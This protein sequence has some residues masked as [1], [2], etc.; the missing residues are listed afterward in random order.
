M[1]LKKSPLAPGAFPDLPEISGVRFASGNSGMRYK[2]R[3]DVMLAEFDPETTV[4]G[5]F[6]KNAMPGAPVDWG[7]KILPAGQARGLVVNAGI[8]NVFTGAAGK[9]TVEDTAATAAQLLNASPEHI[10]VASTGVIGDLVP[11]EKIT[12][13]LPRLAEDL[14]ADAGEAAANCILTTD[15]FAKGA[16]ATAKIGDRLVTISGFAKGSGMI[17]PDMATMLAF[18][19]TDAAV[20]APIL[21]QLLSEANEKSFNCVTVDS[22]TSTSDTVLVFATGRA[23]NEIPA[24]AMDGSL[25]D[26]KRALLDVMAN[27]AQQ[28]ARDGEGASKFITVK[29]TG[30]ESD[31][32][33]KTIALAIAN[34]PLVKTAIAGEDANWGRIIMAV[35][36]SGEKANR[37]KMSLEIGGV[38]IAENGARATTYQEE[39]VIPHMTGTEIEIDVDVAVGDGSAFAWTCDLTHGYIEIN[40]DYRS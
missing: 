10:Y 4:A 32:S 28:V 7:R 35:G 25:G 5:V 24:T 19:F 37:D 17:A 40:A 13:L 6:T 22:D 14:S 9:K 30:A 11:T 27:L 34:S 15:T 26:F 3:D 18:L 8:A 33:A 29:V 1:A 21:Q 20:P 12:N 16:V 31:A 36:K 23:Q 39:D 2:G 38:I